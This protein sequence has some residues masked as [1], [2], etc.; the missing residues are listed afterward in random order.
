MPDLSSHPNTSLRDN[1]LT[2]FFSINLHSL[3]AAYSVNE[4]LSLTLPASP[5]L[6]LFK[7]VFRYTFVAHSLVPFFC[8][9]FH[10]FEISNSRDL[11][12]I[13]MISSEFWNRMHFLHI[14]LFLLP[15]W[16][17]S[18]F[19]RQTFIRSNLRKLENSN[20]S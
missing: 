14:V 18:F 20:F 1:F 15:P 9:S 16:N 5:L 10:P 8:C 6:A 11:L 7:H 4:N 13:M 3:F 12:V 2:C 17:Y 19:F